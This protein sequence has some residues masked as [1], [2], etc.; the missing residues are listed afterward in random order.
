VIYL[1]N[2]FPLKKCFAKFC[3]GEQGGYNYTYSD[4]ANK[5]NMLIGLA[6]SEYFQEFNAIFP[7]GIFDP[8][9]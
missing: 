1:L 5:P 8:N 4:E 7:M 6:P 3:L 9:P 2:S